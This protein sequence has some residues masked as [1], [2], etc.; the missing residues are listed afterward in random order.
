M[1][2]AVCVFNVSTRM[3]TI[4]NI[5]GGRLLRYQRF[6]ETLTQIQEPS[7]SDLR[8]ARALL[9]TRVSL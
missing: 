5:N 3:C 9:M 2:A 4:K 8:A 1:F 7:C 6:L